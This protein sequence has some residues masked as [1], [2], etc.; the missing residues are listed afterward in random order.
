MLPL[1]A[2]KVK[3]S[4]WE[5]L[6]VYRLLRKSIKYNSEDKVNFM[7]KKYENQQESK[8]RFLLALHTCDRIVQI[9][10]IYDGANSAKGRSIS[11]Q[12]LLAMKQSNT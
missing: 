6:E 11:W 7:G 3:G 12:T 2:G 8:A 9:I 4:K 5:L 1:T 10:T